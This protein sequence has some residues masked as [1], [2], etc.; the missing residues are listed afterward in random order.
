MSD[1]RLTASAHRTRPGFTAGEIA[2]VLAMMAILVTIAAPSFRSLQSRYVLGGAAK[3]LAGDLR[4]AQQLSVTQQQPYGVRIDPPSRSYTVVQLGSPEA[5]VKSVTLDQSV[6][7]DSPTGLDD[8]EV[9]FNSAGA[10]SNS[11]DVVLVHA[12]GT[13]ATVSVRPSGFVTAQ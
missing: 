1:R 3:S 8:D 9:S 2:G 4:Y 12:G 6:A 7:V 11:G 5:T 13:I 10:P